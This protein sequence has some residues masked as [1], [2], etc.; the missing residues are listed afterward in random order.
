MQGGSRSAIIIKPYLYVV[1]SFSIIRGNIIEKVG[2]AIEYVIL[3]ITESVDSISRDG[4]D[5]SYM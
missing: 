4:L 2:L 1:Y 3:S 5:C